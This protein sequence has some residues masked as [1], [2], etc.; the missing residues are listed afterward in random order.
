MGGAEKGASLISNGIK[1]RLV[2]ALSAF[3]RG[4]NNAVPLRPCSMPVGH[5]ERRN[6]VFHEQ[7]GPV[8]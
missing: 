3:G 8:G 2:G 6:I 4:A 7:A 5:A 1:R